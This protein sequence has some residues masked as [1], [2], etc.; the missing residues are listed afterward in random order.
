MRERYVVDT[1]VLIA[2]SAGDPHRNRE[3]DATPADVNLREIVWN[4]LTEF[5]L[6]PAKMV[7]DFEGKI[8]D[9][10]EKNLNFNDYGIQVLMKKYS[11]CA[12]EHVNVSYDI[13]GDGELPDTLI[14]AIH[15]GADRKMVAAALASHASHGDGCVAFAGDTDWHDWEEIL[16][17]HGI[18]I[19]PVIEAWSRQ[20][21]A[22]KQQR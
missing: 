20:K 19:E 18:I 17:Q 8:A 9:E 3:I 13:N 7:L 4:W 16:T 11:T 12:M 21:H 14:G 6:S 15:D 2:A 1:N 10:Y 22:E 5:E